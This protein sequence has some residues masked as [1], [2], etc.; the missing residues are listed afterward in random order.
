[1]A[2][3]LPFRGLIYNSKKVGDLSSV[4]APPYDVISRKAAPGYFKKH[5]YNVIRL[6]LGDPSLGPDRYR[7]CASYFRKWEQKGILIPEEEPAYYFYRVDF[8]MDKGERKTRRGFIGLCRLE[9]FGNGMIFP[10]ER[11]HEDQKRDRLKVLEACG[12]NVSPIFS[13]YSDPFQTI[14]GLF[15]KA[16]PPSPLFNYVDGHHLRHSLWSVRDPKLLRNIRERMRDKAVFIADG[17]HRYEAALAYR[18]E[19]PTCGDPFQY[20]MMYFCPFEDEGLLILPSHRLI[21]NLPHFDRISFEA[22]LRKYFHVTA[23]PFLPENEHE[24]RR[25]FFQALESEGSRGKVFGVFIHGNDHYTLLKVKKGSSLLSRIQ[26]D[27]PAVLQKL[28]VMILHRCILE[29]LLGIP[30]EEQN[31]S[32]IRI[33]KNQNR[34][35]DLVERGSFQLAFLLNPPKIE[36]VQEVASKGKVMPQK[37]TFFYP[38]LPTGLVINKVV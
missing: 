38:K 27:L 16:L 24:K 29:G 13:L 10:H 5:P 32:H 3:I 33:V 23:F 12:A 22:D 30:E 31:Q 36:E 1:M 19:N 28:D 15:E 6:E 17:H 4:T 20:V 9:A 18:D 8:P 2:D 14:N 34:A 26:R 25:E 7:R 35:I 11:T 37:S 21:F